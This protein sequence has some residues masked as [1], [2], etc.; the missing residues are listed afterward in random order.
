MNKEETC[1]F[2]GNSIPDSMIIRKLAD[3]NK[4]IGIICEFCLEKAN[5]VE[6]E[7]NKRS[8]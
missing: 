1:Y 8:L 2:C 6:Q 3:K 5:E 7:Q 4:V